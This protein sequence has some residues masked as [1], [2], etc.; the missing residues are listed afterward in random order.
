M[1]GQKKVLGYHLFL[2]DIALRLPLHPP[3][4]RPRTLLLLLWLLLLLLLAL[5]LLLRRLILSHDVFKLRP[6]R[7]HR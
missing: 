6:Q 1:P 5:A 3:R 7:L 4:A 2:L